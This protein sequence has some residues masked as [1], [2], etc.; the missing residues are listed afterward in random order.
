MGVDLPNSVRYVKNGS[1][2]RWWQAAKANGQVH[3]GWTNIPPE[4]LKNPDFAKI[5]LLVRK[6]FTDPGAAT[7]D[8]NALRSLLDAPSQHVWITFEDGC[9]WW[10]TVRD[11]AEINPNGEDQSHGNFWLVCDRPWS[12]RSL[13]GR[14]LAITDLPGTVTATAGFRGTVSEPRAS[15]AILRVVR[16]ERNEDVVASREGRA[17]YEQSVFNIIKQLRWRDF[18]QLVDLILDRTGWKRVSTI[19]GTREGIDIEVANLTADEIAFVQVKSSA[20]QTVLDDYLRRFNAQRD[21]YARMIFAV[22]SVDGQLVVPA[23]SPVQ[24]WTCEKL[25]ELVVRLGL[26]EW[27]ENK[28]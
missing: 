18:E 4:L 3:A 1:G 24:L 20:T 15:E 10:C 14:P 7:R 5:E 19:G 22:H 6:E 26:G 27:V 11:G 25:A 16:D 13:G 17:R 28:L 8:F 2:G 9:M 23:N 21:R 12:N